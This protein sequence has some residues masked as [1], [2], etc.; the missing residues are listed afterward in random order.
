[1]CE[2]INL[3]IKILIKCQQFLACVAAAAAFYQ[4][5]NE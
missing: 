1:M 3:K 4:S 5:K 2:E